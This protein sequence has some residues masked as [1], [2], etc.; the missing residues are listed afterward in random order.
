MSRRKNYGEGYGFDFHGAFTEKADAMKKEAKTPGSFI[1]GTPTAKGYRW[2]VMSPRKNPRK[3]RRANPRAGRRQL[4]VGDSMTGGIKEFF[5][6]EP[7]AKY[8]RKLAEK[9]YDRIP[10]HVVESDGTSLTHYIDPP[11]EKNPTKLHK[12]IKSKSAEKA[13]AFAGRMRD[14]YPGRKIEVK[15][16]SDGS[17]DVYVLNQRMNPA[18]LIVLGANPHLLRRAN[19]PAA[20]VPAHNSVAW[21]KR[22]GSDDSYM[23]RAVAQ[24]YPG[25]SLGQ[26]SAKE[27]SD[28]AQLAARLKHPQG[29]PGSRKNVEF[30]EFEHGVFHPWTRRPR[31]G[32]KQATRRRCNSEDT[33]RAAADLRETFTGAP[34]EWVT[35]SDEPHVPTGDYAQLGELLA[36]YIKPLSSGQVQQINFKHDRPALVSA[37]NARQLYLVGGDQDISAALAVFGARDRGDGT[38]ELGELRRLDYKQRKEHVPDPDVDEWRHELGEE[39]GIRPVLVFDSSNKKLLIEGGDYEVRREGIVN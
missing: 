9:I 1:K 30:G 3:H 37:T 24:L 14:R 28:V 17:W 16:R 18:E 5:R 22:N 36:L 35:V 12:H 38:L 7:A 33:E 4:T 27:L 20:I 29:A 6:W 23:Q 11:A 25:K 31:S 21:G 10:V 2:I 8:A 32:R 39:N 34:A 19:P 15:E 26:L 13:Y